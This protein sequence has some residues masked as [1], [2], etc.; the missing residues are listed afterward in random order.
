MCLWSLP[1]CQN[2]DFLSR[3][4]SLGIGQSHRESNLATRAPDEWRL[5]QFRSFSLNGLHRDVTAEL[6]DSDL[7]AVFSGRNMQASNH[8]SIIDYNIIPII[9]LTSGG[10]MGVWPSNLHIFWE[11]QEWWKLGDPWDTC[12]LHCAKFESRSKAIMSRWVPVYSKWELRTSGAKSS[13][14]SV[15]FGLIELP[16]VLR[17]VRYIY[18]QHLKA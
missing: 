18:G 14:F 3:I 2:G 13:T 8:Y 12:G 11:L 9:P 16:F 6:P 5:T 4:S 10:S 15:S 17:S 7:D 1:R